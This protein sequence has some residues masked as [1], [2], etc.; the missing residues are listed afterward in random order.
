MPQTPTPGRGLIAPALGD[1]ADGPD[2]VEDLAVQLDRVASIDA[3]TLALR[4]TA[5]STVG[6]AIGNPFT[7]YYATD[8]GELFLSFGA[9][10]IPLNMGP[11]V[12]IGAS[13]EYGGSGD[14]TDSRFLLEDGRALART[15]QYAALFAALGA[16]YGAGDGSTTFNIPDSRGRVTVGTDNMG[17]AA[18]AAGRLPNNPNGRGNVGGEERHTLLAAESG[19][20]SNGSTSTAGSHTHSQHVELVD[21]STGAPNVANLIAYATVARQFDGFVTIGTGE[22]NHTHTLIARNADNPHNN[23]QPYVVKNKIIRVK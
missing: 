8:T 3:G 6:T 2:A 1:I 9:A 13:L 20:N 16:T 15:G 14:P 10:W 4:P 22:G 12:P 21:S 19:V 17:T 11:P 23:L 5:N 7:F 18:G